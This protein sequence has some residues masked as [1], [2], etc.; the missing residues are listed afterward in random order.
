[1]QDRLAAAAELADRLH[2]KPVQAVDIA[3]ERPTVPVFLL[4]EGARVATK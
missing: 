1:M 4:P 3:D 2:A